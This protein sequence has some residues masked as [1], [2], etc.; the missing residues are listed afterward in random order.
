MRQV[1]HS[2]RY[3]KCDWHFFSLPLSLIPP[4]V[5]CHDYSKKRKH[6]LSHVSV[7]NMRVNIRAM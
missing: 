7:Y 1:Y 5:T 3:G 6:N 4:L 2:K